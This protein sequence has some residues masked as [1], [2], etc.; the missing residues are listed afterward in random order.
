MACGSAYGRT[1]QGSRQGNVPE[2]PSR[3]TTGLSQQPSLS[4]SGE[5]TTPP[6]TFMLSPRSM[7][8]SKLRRFASK[9]RNIPWKLNSLQAKFTGILCPFSSRSPGQLIHPVC[10]FSSGTGRWISLPTQ[11]VA[12]VT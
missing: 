11:Q 12:Q 9:V 1:Q 3:T 10:E 8:A 4:P 5:A 7:Q 2:P 6:L